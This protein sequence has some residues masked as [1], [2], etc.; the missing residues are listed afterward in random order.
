MNTTPTTT[1]ESEP[2]NLDELST[3]LSAPMFADRETLKEAYDYFFGVLGAINAADRAAALTAAMVLTNTIAQKINALSGAGDEPKEP[4]APKHFSYW[5]TLT[6]AKKTVHLF[7]GE[8]ERDYEYAL[9]ASPPDGLLKKYYTCGD[10][11]RQY[12]EEYLDSM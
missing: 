12:A 3:M 10:E 9:E 1:N 2:Q 5:F 11:A 8:G 4:K 6:N 7:T